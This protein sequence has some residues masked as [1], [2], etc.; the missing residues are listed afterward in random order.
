MKLNFGIVGF[1]II[2]ISSC[3]N[4]SLDQPS[5]EPIQKL[6]K[7]VIVSDAELLFQS[8]LEK[9]GGK[10][11]DF[12]HYSFVFRNVEYSFE[13]SE[14]NYFYSREFSKGANGF[15]DRMSPNSF[16]REIDG[17][18]IELSKEET[19]KYRASINSVIYFATLPYK[20]G[21]ASVNKEIVGEDSI[22]GQAYKMMKVSFGQEGGG[23]DF[24]DE[25]LYWFNSNTHT[26]DYF[27]YNYTVNQGGV[28]F[29]S[30]FNSRVVNGV[31][32]QDYINFEAP[33][34][35]ALKDL[36]SLFEN[37]ELKELSRIITKDI[38][39]LSEN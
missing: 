20:L 23:E 6:E 22:N 21:D 4:E 16:T 31:I 29:R 15:F 24:D 37:G 26:M 13:N 2:L 35:T 10:K 9:H 14:S 17:I 11:Y 34:G 28:R 38:K 8:V 30:A 3:G 7:E 36:S 18:E 19:T 33:V 25:Y 1:I 39:S 27:A 32:F 5:P 12:A